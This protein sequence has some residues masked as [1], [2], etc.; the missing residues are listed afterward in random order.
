M[1]TPLYNFNTMLACQKVLS[2]NIGVA[3]KGMDEVDEFYGYPW[4]RRFA[5]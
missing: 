4:K 2:E 3:I 1:D 5:S